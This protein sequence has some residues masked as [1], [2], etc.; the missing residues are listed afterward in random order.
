MSIT[1]IYNNGSIKKYNSLN[2]I[3]NYNLV[4]KINCSHNKLLS[5][6]DCKY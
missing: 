6:P 1:I 2:I 4:S 5:L 3:I